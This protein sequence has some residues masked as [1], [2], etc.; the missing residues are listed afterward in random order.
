MGESVTFAG[1]EEDRGGRGLRGVGEVGSGAVGR[2][3]VVG[4]LGGVETPGE[5]GVS[6]MFQNFEKSKFQILEI[7]RSELSRCVGH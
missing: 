2:V 4:G 1:I 7:F 3:G 5:V 6:S